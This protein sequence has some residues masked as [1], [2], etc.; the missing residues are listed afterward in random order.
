[1]KRN[2]LRFSQP[3]FETVHE[4]EWLVT[5][6]LGGYASS[7]LSGSHSRRYHGWLVASMHPPTGRTV[8]V[9]KAAETVLLPSGERLELAAH[10]FPGTISPA[11]YTYLKAFK[12]LPIP[13]F[14]YEGAG[15]SLTRRIWMPHGSNT[16]VVEYENTGK[17][18]YQ[19]EVKPFFVFRDYHSLMKEN[20]ANNFWIEW[21]DER[22]AAVYPRYGA[23][24]FYMRFTSGNF[25]E[26][27]WWY[28]NFVYR[29]E[30]YRGLD[31]R[32]DAYTPGFIQFELRPG[33]VAHIL[34]TT[35][36][37]M[38]DSDPFLLKK[39]EIQRIRHI[40]HDAAVNTLV[41]SL[42]FAG[43]EEADKM[44]RIIQDL[45]VSADQFIVAR[46]SSKGQTIIA[47]YHWFTDW[48]RD[49]MIAMRG[50]V[51]ALGKKSLAESI[52]L[53]FM[54]YLDQGMIPNRFP[55]EGEEPEYNTMDATLWL[56]VV[57]HEYVERFHDTAF[58]RR[59]YPS[60]TSIIEWH[61]RGTRYDIHMLPDGLLFGGKGLVQL[62]WMDAKVGDVVV[63]PRHGCP[64]EI[65]A[66][67]YNALMIYG[68]LGRKIEA[69]KNPYA[70]LA[71]RVK[72]AFVDAFWNGTYL[73]DVV[74]P[75]EYADDAIRPNQ[76]YAL[77]LP[78][79]LLE[80]KMAN[81]MLATVTSRLL[82]PLGLRSL[83]PA[84]M[85]F[86][87]SYGGDPWKRDHAYHQG[88]V[89]TFLLGEYWRACLRQKKY[90][91]AAKKQIWTQIKPL[92][93]HFYGNDGLHAV[94]EIFDGQR[95]ATG[96]GCI[97]QAWSVGALI[98]T[99]DHLG[100]KA[101]DAS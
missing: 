20:P 58:I 34:F 13:S 77:S 85:D 92:L 72:S 55:D 8:L 48:G 16:T 9:S 64:V 62:T 96:R 6:G 3:D 10:E 79:P 15:F 82:T 37:G 22:L 88:T 101:S 53:T 95:P 86:V 100:K 93:A 94:S 81:S 25:R 71:K 67:W 42:S 43:E 61:I 90:S 56:F 38:M 83:D 36:P 51:L 70:G 49:T 40:E 91:R 12:P 17:Q 1:M 23:S 35:E 5:N 54:Q 57:L 24:P 27:G 14:L 63:T 39:Q 69:G 11:G 4:K 73:N 80:E 30:A 32:E 31:D 46:E 45:A 60:L 26:D 7:T 29:K 89:W 99:F 98:H 87:S 19:L 65:N 21:K 74:I 78:Y 97:Q 76:L 50:L 41:Q 33:A 66:L 75:G 47:G 84:H 44:K 18:T 2:L 28:K 59:I 52:L 68:D